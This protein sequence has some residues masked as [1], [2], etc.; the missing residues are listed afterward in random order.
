M[1]TDR[2]ELFDE[3]SDFEAD[4]DALTSGLQ[5]PD[6]FLVDVAPS[7]VETAFTM[8]I[9][10]NAAVKAKKTVAFFS[11][12]MSKPLLVQRMLCSE[13]DVD[14]QKLKNGDLNE[15]EWA[16][17]MCTANRISEAPLHIDDTAGI[18][19]LDLST[20][21]RR[22]KAEHGL[23]LII[24][25]NLQMMQASS[26]K[27]SDNRQNKTTEISCSLKVLARELHV[28]IIALSRLSCGVKRH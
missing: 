8:N 12:A 14:F 26:S 1:N 20:K 28:P 2:F 13:G 11:L 23:N 19:V 25:D 10:V 9:A 4:L 22:L 18:S 5:P 6:L 17:L 24:I 15:E 21:A 16:R 7:K 27:S 3:K